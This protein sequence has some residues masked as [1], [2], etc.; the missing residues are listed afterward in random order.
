MAQRSL[1]GEVVEQ[2]GN[3][4]AA[5]AQRRNTQA[6]D[7]Q[8][9]VKVFAKTPGLDLVEQVRLD[10]TDDPQIDPDAL[11]RAQ[12][13]QGFLLQHAQQFD[14][15]GQGQAFHLVEKQGAAIGVFDAP[16]TLA[17]S[18]GKGPAFMAEQL[19]FEQVLGNRR[20]VQRDEGLAGAGAEI[21]QAAR[22]PLLAAASVAT[23]EDVHRGAGQLEDLPAQ[24]FHRLRY[25]K[26]LRLDLVLAGKLLAQLA[27]LA[28]QAALVQG[29]AHTVEQ[30]LGGE[31]LFDKVVGT[32]AQGLYRHGHIAVTGNQDHRQVAIQ[33]QQL[34]QQLQAVGARHTH[35]AD[36]HPGKVAVDERQGLGRTGATAHMQT[37]QLQPLLH[38]LTDCRFIVDDYHLPGHITS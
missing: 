3:V 2:Q 8:A 10:R 31:G 13:L 33:L 17:L 21:V 19:A 4:L 6:G 22:H 18:A 20:A 27:V 9:V 1:V 38:G 25:A 12:A 36:H 37:G 24:V 34:V 26:Q 16:D 35:I 29:A 30:T 5:L 23:Q 28:N 7:I 32:L 14:L 11:V 15:L